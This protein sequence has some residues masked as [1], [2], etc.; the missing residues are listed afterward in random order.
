MPEGSCRPIYQEREEP[1]IEEELE[2][3][4][5]RDPFMKIYIVEEILETAKWTQT[6]WIEIGRVGLAILEPP[7][8]RFILPPPEAIET[9]K[10]LP[11]P[12]EEIKFYYHY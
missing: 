12:R 3:E 7:K 5:S 4:E 9:A 2:K 11:I 1:A 6:F 10:A 8:Y